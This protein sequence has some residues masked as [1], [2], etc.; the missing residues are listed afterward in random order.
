MGVV[1]VT[2]DSFSDGGQFFSSEA[3]VLHALALVK[4]GADILD[5]GGESSRPGALPIDSQEE[6]RRVIPVVRALRSQTDAIL[7][8]DTTKAEVAAEALAAGAEIIND[9]NALEDPELARVAASAGAGVV[10]MNMR[11]RPATMQQ[12]DLTHPDLV[13]LVAQ[14]L[15]EAM[16]RAEAAGVAREAICLDPGLGFGK[17]VEQNVALVAE[18]PRLM[19]LGRPVLL[20]PSRKSFI[21]ALTQR[22]VEE[23]LAGTLAACACAVMRG[24]HLLRVHDVAE[25]ADAVRVA[26]AIASV[27]GP[28]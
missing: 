26:S 16:A 15:G 8:V 5:I 17:T 14:L 24:V 3:A 2:P 18:L 9:I 7:S 10:L 13:G 27:G 23:R 28:P 21:G 19:G 22:P 20:G 25:A 12:G 4:A 11:G 1:N 6:L